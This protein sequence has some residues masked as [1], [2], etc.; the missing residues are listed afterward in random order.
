MLSFRLRVGARVAVTVGLSAL[1]SI[2]VSFC[3]GVIN[4]WC[5]GGGVAQGLLFELSLSSQSACSAET[6][7]CRGGW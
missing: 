2:L 4:V 6:A 3:D 7:V 5:V 1:A